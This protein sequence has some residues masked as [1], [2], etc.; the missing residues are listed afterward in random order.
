MISPLLNDLSPVTFRSHGSTA[1]R[2]PE[3]RGVA[4]G[5][6]GDAV[7][8]RAVLEGDREAFRGI[9]ERY[10][11]RV[12]T[13][14]FRI[15]HHAE[16]AEDLAQETF[17][18]AFRALDRYDPGRPFHTW[19]LTIATRLTLNRLRRK[20]PR[21]LSLDQPLGGVDEPGDFTFHDVVESKE[22]SPSEA[23]S[24]E[25]LRSRLEEATDR[26]PAAMRA[27]FNLR[28]QEDLPLA[29]IGQITGMSLS[30][31]KVTLHRARKFLRDWI[32]P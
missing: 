32:Q 8:I 29:E 13:H 4:R 20:E 10:Q 7:L 28:Y 15:V 17:L 12:H 27:V 26:L 31:V 30:A 11:A 3:G 21:P 9:V 6:G 14:I 19:L 18:R 2:D 24:A 22:E 23:A 16:E 25:E 1:P 5:S